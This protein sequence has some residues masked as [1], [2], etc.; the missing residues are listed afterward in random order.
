[1]KHT[2]AGKV[3][4]QG[5]K[6]LF[7]FAAR[8][9]QQAATLLVTLLAARFLPP[10][11][12]GTYSLAIVFIVL[13]QTMTYTGFYQFILTAKEDDAA[14]LS[15]CFW[16]ILG[17]A[18][19][20][21]AG[22]ALAAFP[23]EWMF[24]AKPLG[25]V[26][27][28][29]ALVQP[30]ASFGAW[31]SAALLRSGAITRNFAVMFAQNLAA[32]TGGAFLLWHWHSVFALVAFR[33]LRVVTGAALHA[34]LGCDRPRMIFRRDL[35]G[36]AAAFSAGLYGSRLLNFLARY[37]ADLMLGMLHSPA[38]V[39]LYRFGNRIATGATDIINQPMSSFAATQFGSAGRQD[40]DLATPLSRFAGTITL[41][42]GIVGAVVIVF[43]RDVIEIFFR[44]SYLPALVVTYAMALR[45][46]ASAGQLL[47]EPA[48]AA[49][50]RT[51]WVMIFDMVSAA[52]AVAAI[53][54]ASPFGLEAL[55]WTQVLVVLGTTVWAF[56][57][58]HW[59]GTVRVGGAI[60]N[61]AAALVLSGCYG[62]V[63][64]AG[65]RVL[66]T[67]PFGR[68]E[69]LGLGLALAAIAG[70]ALV[71]LATRLRV[72]SFQAFSG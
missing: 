49:I 34:M 63:L 6:A 17:L 35:A 56:W 48:F 39:G 23:L 25:T 27:V 36:K 4:R 13:V 22:L 50:G 72:F 18:S 40:K 69:A 65:R 12:Y 16:L 68:L 14:V 67:L 44:S 64:H 55:A 47:V 57:L 7:A 42:S 19:L 53:F 60:R 8:S 62:I 71:A 43:A 21:S 45:G 41:L 46:A 37:A 38:A 66:S 61:F 70:L 54:A 5:A 32:L 20:A 28:L 58:L 15:T 11:Q 51:G 30:L 26:L 24:Q 52:V 31:S 2:R 29:L 59:R 10:A 9:L 3:G 33:Y 1:M